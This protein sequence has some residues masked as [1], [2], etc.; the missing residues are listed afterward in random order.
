M[1]DL[2]RIADEHRSQRERIDRRRVEDLV[3]WLAA[4]WG[5]NNPQFPDLDPITGQ[6][7]PGNVELRDTWYRVVR[8]GWRCENCEGAGHHYLY[9]DDA[10][11]VH[12]ELC[13]QCAGRGYVTSTGTI[14]EEQEPGDTP[15]AHE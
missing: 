13:A 15:P 1:T 4:K 6:A 7:L 11:V 2:D 8:D 10:D 3:R 5:P 14:P 12:L 9:T